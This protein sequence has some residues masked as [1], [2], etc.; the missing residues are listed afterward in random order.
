MSR[1]QK[2]P[3]K[4]TKSSISGRSSSLPP[5]E[6]LRSPAVAWY[7]GTSE[8]PLSKFIKVAT[9][10]DLREL[11]IYGEPPEAELLTAWGV[12]YQEFLDGMQDK[13]TAHKVKLKSEIDKLEYDYRLIQLCIQRLSFGP[14][15]WAIEQLRRRVRVSGEF[16]P[17]DQAEYFQQLLIVMNHA[18]SLKHR[19]IERSAEMDIV[20]RKAGAAGQQQENQFDQLI[21]RVCLFC[22]FQINRKETMT[23]EFIELFK[24]MK[25]QED[26]L[27]R[28][29]E[30]SKARR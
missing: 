19:I 25:A 28:Q 12:I 16:N 3:L 21:A 20:Y 22:K 18:V 6:P 4:F 30:T 2:K 23:S 24:E 8:I 15:Q 27:Q 5:L 29:L 1:K 14:D 7:R 9:K 17:E 10:G 11:I 26:A 13:K